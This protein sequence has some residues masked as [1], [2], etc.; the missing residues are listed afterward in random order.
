MEANLAR[1]RAAVERFGERLAVTTE[2]DD[3]LA[4]EYH[5]LRRALAS[6]FQ[7]M[8]HEAISRDD[9]DLNA[10]KQL[11]VTKMHEL[12]DGRVESRFLNVRGYTSPHPDLYALLAARLGTAVPGWRLRLLTGDKIHT[13]RR[14]R[15]LRDLGL[16]VEVGESQSESTY[17][18]RSLSPDLT[19]G[20]AF[21]L[22][23]N[24]LDAKQLDSGAR[25]WIIQLAESSAPLPD[26]KSTPK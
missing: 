1:A 2:F 11:V 24:A 10:I 21:Q 3:S 5:R 9:H 6:T 23:R 8:A 25:A 15:E 17:E 7:S 14:T 26:R 18:L 22:R 4:V 12:F 13:E 20:A 19:F 16:D